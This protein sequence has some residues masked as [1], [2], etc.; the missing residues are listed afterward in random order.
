MEVYRKPRPVSWLL[1]NEDDE[2]EK[3]YIVEDDEMIVQLLKQRF[4]KI[5]SGRKCAE[6]P[7]CQSGSD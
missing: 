7:S 4:G 5:L 6:F 3:I 1:Q 2:K